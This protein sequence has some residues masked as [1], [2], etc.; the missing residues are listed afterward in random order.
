MKAINDYLDSLPFLPDDQILDLSKLKG[1]AMNI[2]VMRY[3]PICPINGSIVSA[4]I[5]LMLH[6]SMDLGQAGLID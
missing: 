3:R 5:E 2:F 4:I 6:Q 1:L